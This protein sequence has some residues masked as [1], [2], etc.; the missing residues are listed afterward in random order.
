MARTEVIK[1]ALDGSQLVSIGQALVKV[2]NH[3]HADVVSIIGSAAVGALP[4]KRPPFEDSAVMANKV[5][6]AD[7]RPAQLLNVVALDALNDL[8]VREPT[9]GEVFTSMMKCDSTNTSHWIGV[10][11]NTAVRPRM[12]R[13]DAR[14]AVALERQLIDRGHQSIGGWIGCRALLPA[15]G[16]LCWFATAACRQR[17]PCRS[18]QECTAVH[19]WCMGRCVRAISVWFGRW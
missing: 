12:T 8:T 15:S 4:V 3:R 9:R 1:R 6:V 13:G 10:V 2:A 19:E 7:R 17:K 5:V 11:A 18:E 14:L 16:W